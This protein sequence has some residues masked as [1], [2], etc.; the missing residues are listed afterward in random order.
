MLSMFFRS[1][2]KVRVRE[3]FPIGHFRTPVYIRGC[4][5][6]VMV[7][8]GTF[9]NPETLAYNLQTKPCALYKVRFNQRD[10]WQDYEGSSEDTI[11]LDIYEHWLEEV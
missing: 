4:E 11:V 5:G 8:L 9:L 7:Y 6:E 2:D 1:G 3:D 10:V